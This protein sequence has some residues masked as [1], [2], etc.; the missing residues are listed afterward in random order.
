[1]YNVK[2]TYKRMIY[3][4]EALSLSFFR[5]QIKN[6]IYVLANNTIS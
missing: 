2:Y 4:I 6:L 3:F 5:N 1:M